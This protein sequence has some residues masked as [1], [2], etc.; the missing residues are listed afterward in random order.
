MVCLV[1]PKQPVLFGLSPDSIAVVRSQSL[2][3]RSGDERQAVGV[4]QPDTGLQDVLGAQS[5][6][7]ATG[8]LQVLGAVRAISGE[9]FGPSLESSPIDIMQRLAPGGLDRCAEQ[10]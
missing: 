10:C 5:D 9:S 6:D 8:Y 4:M 7:Q 1:S 3:G 2:E